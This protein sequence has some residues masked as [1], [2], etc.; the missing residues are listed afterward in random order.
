MVWGLAAVPQA[1]QQERWQIEQQFLWWDA[2]SEA[3]A[4][5]SLRQLLNTP[6]EMPNKQQDEQVWSPGERSNL[7]A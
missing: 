1:E 4:V 5:L 6:V 3:L 2:G 7:E